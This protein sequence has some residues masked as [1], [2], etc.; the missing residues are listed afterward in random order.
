MQLH[1][2]LSRILIG[3]EE[4]ELTQMCEDHASNTYLN[5]A[6]KENSVKAGKII[7]RGTKGQ[8]PPKQDVPP[9][10]HPEFMNSSRK[11]IKD[12]GTCEGSTGKTLPRMIGEP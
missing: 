5:L 7:A 4:Y 8:T 12:C 2:D 6:K 3:N 1:E 9:P 10:Y 11:Q